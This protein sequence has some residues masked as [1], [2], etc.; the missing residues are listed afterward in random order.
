MDF[1]NVHFNEHI[2]VVTITSCAQFSSSFFQIPF[3]RLE[4]NLMLST[5]DVRDFNE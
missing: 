3:Y 4:K 1:F 5:K 2:R